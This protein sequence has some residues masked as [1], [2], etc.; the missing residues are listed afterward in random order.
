MIKWGVIGAGKMGRTFAHSIKEVDNAKLVA[1][2]SLDSKRL[3]S[4]A[5]NFNI[6]KEF[7]FTSY[8]EI[9]KNNDIDAIYISTLNNTH[10]ELIKLCASYKKNILCEK[11]FC[12]FIS[13]QSYFF[14]A[15]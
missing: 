1:I 3:D 14:C 12:F 10:I 7:R 9:C 13:I 4:F 11:P 8:E 2:A 15:R 6:N 5:S